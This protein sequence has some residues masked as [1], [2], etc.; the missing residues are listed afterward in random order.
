M[1]LTNT[2]IPAVLKDSKRISMRHLIYKCR[3]TCQLS[4]T[5]WIYLNTTIPTLTILGL[6]IIAV[7]VKCKKNKYKKRSAKIYRLARNRGKTMETFGYNAVPV[8]TGDKDN[9]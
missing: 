6:G 7:Y 8:C 5:R 4:V 1:C 2:D 9:V 3:K